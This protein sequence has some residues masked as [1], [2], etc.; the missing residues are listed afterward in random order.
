[1]KASKPLPDLFCRASA[2]FLP[3]GRAFEFDGNRFTVL[4]MAGHRIAKVKVE[5]V[6]AKVA[7]EALT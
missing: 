1:M 5:T 4:T 6:E 3:A 2:R 7:E